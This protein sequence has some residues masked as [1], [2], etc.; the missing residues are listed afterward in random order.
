MA[1][2][3]GRDE[4]RPAKGHADPEDPHQS[5]PDVSI[6]LRMSPVDL[7]VDLPLKAAPQSLG[8]PIGDDSGPGG[9]AWGGKG[10]MDSHHTSNP[11]ED[12]GKH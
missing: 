6:S 1:A 4:D 8:D 3:E 2:L 10:K 11:V 12:A 7:A 9:G 5:C